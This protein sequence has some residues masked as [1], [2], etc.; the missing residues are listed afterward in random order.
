MLL[1][2]ES[3]TSGVAVAR[4]RRECA[5]PNRKF[6]ERASSW[7]TPDWWPGC[8][9]VNS[10]AATPSF[11]YCRC[12]PD[13]LYHLVPAFAENI[14]ILS[15]SLPCSQNLHLCHPDAR[16]EPLC[17]RSGCGSKVP[18]QQPLFSIICPLHQ[19]QALAPLRLQYQ[20]LSPATLMVQKKT[21][22][23]RGQML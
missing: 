1:P 20:T 18:D 17:F 15:P 8:L 13:A 7:D 22:R 5:P 4:V 19:I 3:H 14:L 11:L 10:F 16:S 9:S 12:R 21:R 6:S 2:N 23:R